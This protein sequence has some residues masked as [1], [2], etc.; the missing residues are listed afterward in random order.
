MGRISLFEGGRGEN[1][2]REAVW[3]DTLWEMKLFWRR[4]QVLGTETITVKDD[5]GEGKIVEMER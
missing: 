1:L 5:L 4:V 2:N 3:E